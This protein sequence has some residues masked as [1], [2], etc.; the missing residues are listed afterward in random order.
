MQQQ[1]P[2]GSRTAAGRS[3]DHDKFITDTHVQYPSP[4]GEEETSRPAM[5]AP[6]KCA[7]TLSVWGQGAPTASS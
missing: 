6:R 7:T 5:T 2:C 1:G 3:S 4:Q